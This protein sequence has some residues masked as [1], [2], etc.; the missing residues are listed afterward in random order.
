MISHFISDEDAVLFSIS[1]ISQ[2]LPLL[3]VLVVMTLYG[4][5]SEE[6]VPRLWF[7]LGPRVSRD[8]LDTTVCLGVP[9][10]SP[11]CGLLHMLCPRP[12]QPFPSLP[13]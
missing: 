12:G 9:I 3:R 8:A 1:I 7:H 2:N 4:Q 6:M 11:N 5:L 13:T 10:T